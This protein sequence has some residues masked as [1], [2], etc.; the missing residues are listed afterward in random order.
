MRNIILSHLYKKVEYFEQRV[1]IDA[2]S[3]SSWEILISSF[4]N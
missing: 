1:V 2:A 3:N 4:L